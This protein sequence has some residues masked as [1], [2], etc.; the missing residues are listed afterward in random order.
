MTLFKYSYIILFCFTYFIGLLILVIS[1]CRFVCREMKKL[2]CFLRACIRPRYDTIR[3]INV[4]S[5]A[6]EMASFI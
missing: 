2:S 3:L 6:D 5:K 1:F 4:R